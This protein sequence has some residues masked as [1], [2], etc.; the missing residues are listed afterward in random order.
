LGVRSSPEP[1]RSAVSSQSSR[2]KRAKRFLPGT[3]VREEGR[4]ISEPGLLDKVVSIH[5]ALDDA[6]IAHAFGGALALA[7]HVEHP[8]ATADIDVNISRSDPGGR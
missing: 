5:E 1:D 2:D 4:A 7:F 6:G 3:T 8:R